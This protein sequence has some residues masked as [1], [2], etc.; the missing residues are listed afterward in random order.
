MPVMPWLEARGVS[1]ATALAWYR[2]RYG[3][4]KE[5]AEGM[6]GNLECNQATLG[7]DAE[8]A[9]VCETEITYSWMQIRA[10]AIVVRKGRLTPVL[11]VGL[12]MRALDWPDSRHL[13]L[14]LSFSPDGRSATLRDRAPDGTRLV[15]APSVC[16]ARETTLDK[17][18]DA[19]ANHAAPE[20]FCPFVVDD[21]G[22]RRVAR[23]R[24]SLPMMEGLPTTLH[25]CAQAK[26]DLKSTEAEMSKQ[27]GW[28][29]NEAHVASRFIQRTCNEVGIYVWKN[30]R[31]VLQKPPR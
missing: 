8:E 23:G 31:F 18:E 22:H 29:A 9:A 24:D 13:D 30:G 11:D 6:F 2:G 20:G 7:D 25:D 27:G 14:A 21:L 10:F 19:L 12:G 1:R 28:I 5:L 17:C 3:V 16:R 4:D 15:E 26:S